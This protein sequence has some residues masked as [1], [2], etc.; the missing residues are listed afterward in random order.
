MTYGNLVALAQN[1][2]KRMLAY[3]AISH[4]GYMLIGV[5]SMNELGYQAIAFYTMVYAFM[6]IGAFTILSLMKNKGIIED[7]RLE[8][9]AGLGKKYPIISLA[10]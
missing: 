8:S 5:V 7:E 9:F 10:C 4:A 6:N 1:N 3:S 2:V